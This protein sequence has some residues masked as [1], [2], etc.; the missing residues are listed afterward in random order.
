MMVEMN[1]A[2]RA[3]MLFVMIV[4]QIGNHLAY[5]I[6]CYADWRSVTEDTHAALIASASMFTLRCLFASHLKSFEKLKN[7]HLHFTSR[8]AVVGGKEIV[9]SNFKRFCCV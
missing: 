3:L 5:H 8:A 4:L 7:I 2:H 1:S 6:F 9:G